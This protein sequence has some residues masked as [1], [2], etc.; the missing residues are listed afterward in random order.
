MEFQGRYRIPASPDTVWAALNDV[1]V[2]KYCI[3]G[4][5]SL[6]KS[7]PTTFE[8]VATVK[9]GPMK[10]AFRSKIRLS[11]LDPPKNCRLTGEGQ[12]GAAGF[13]KG[14]ADVALEPDGDGTQLHYVARAAI[15]GKLAQIGQRLLD[16]AAKQIADDFFSRFSGA[17]SAAQTAALEPDPTLEPAPQPSE[18]PG[19]ARTQERR[20]PEIWAL[21]LIGIVIV[22][23]LIIWS[24]L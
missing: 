6:V 13:A 9:I 16:S 22:A 14:E 20:A 15:G 5:E 21:G 3:P 8:A 19:P 24:Q 12:G 17:L 10:A 2:L 4:C 11:E 7:S 23:A 18:A 1:D